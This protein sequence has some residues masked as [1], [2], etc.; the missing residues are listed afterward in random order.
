MIDLIMYQQT[1]GWELNKELSGQIESDRQLRRR[2][3]RRDSAPG[4]RFAKQITVT[5]C[6]CHIGIYGHH[7]SEE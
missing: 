3:A 6:D 2:L 5:Y 1:C 4:R 7:L